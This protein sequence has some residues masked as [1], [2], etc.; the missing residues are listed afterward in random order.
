MDIYYVDTVIG[1]KTNKLQLK[2][3]FNKDKL[4]LIE[5][6]LNDEQIIGLKVVNY[7]LYSNLLNNNEYHEAG[8][9]MYLFY[10]MQCHL[11]KN[12][13]KNNSVINYNVFFKSFKKNKIHQEIILN[14]EEFNQLYIYIK[15]QTKNK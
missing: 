6:V 7:P 11:N 4:F 2:K 15:K 14:N 3:Y 9:G 1:L 10:C 12:I 13:I 5:R 8:Q